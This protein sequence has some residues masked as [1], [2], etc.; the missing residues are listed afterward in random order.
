MEVENKANQKVL[1]IYRGK[2]ENKDW[3][4]KGEKS[5]E[6]IQPSSSP[7]SFLSSFSLPKILSDITN[8]I[9]A[10]FPSR[11]IQVAS[12][13][14]PEAYLGQSQKS[15]TPKLESSH[16][17]VTCRVPSTSTSFLFGGRF[18]Q[19]PASPERFPTL[20]SYRPGAPR[21]NAAAPGLGLF[22]GR[23]LQ[24]CGSERRPPPVCRLLPKKDLTAPLDGGAKH[25][26]R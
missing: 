21:S 6:Q 11:P 17:P 1:T 7:F 9:T 14:V 12:L 2:G 15:Y 25:G 3:K 20:S 16:F 22:S 23:T 4:K 13:S 10:N 19:L 5:A 24:V 18:N 26:G 8:S